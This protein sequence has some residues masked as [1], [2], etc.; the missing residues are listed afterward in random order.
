MRVDPNTVST[1][2]FIVNLHT[3]LLGLSEPFLDAGLTKVRSTLPLDLSM[4][5]VVIDGC[6]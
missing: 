3:V 6:R 4:Q 5:D 1:E 2:G